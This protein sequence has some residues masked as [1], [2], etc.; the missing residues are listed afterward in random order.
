MHRQWKRGQ[1]TCREYRDTAGLCRDRVRKAKA[2][3]ELELG[4]A[5]GVKKKKSFNRYVNRKRKVL[6]CVPSLVRR[7][8]RGD[9]INVYKYLK[10]GGR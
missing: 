7:R 3:L 6:E 9:L 5:R 2:Q 8:L 4:L 10:G 1:V